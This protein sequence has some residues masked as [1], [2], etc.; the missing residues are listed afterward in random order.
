MLDKH[1]GM[2]AG[3]R[4]PHATIVTKRVMGLYCLDVGVPI[5]LVC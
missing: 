5:S 3:A 2:A 1:A 4:I